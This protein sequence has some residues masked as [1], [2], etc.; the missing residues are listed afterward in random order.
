MAAKAG[1]TAASAA[2]GPDAKMSSWPASAGPLLPDTGASTNITSGRSCR[3]VSSNPVVAESPIVPICAHTAPGANAAARPCGNITM[4]TASAV[5]SMVITTRASLVASRAE[6]A[7]RAP[8]AASGAVA[9]GDLS[10]T[11]V[12]RPAATKLRAIADPMMPVPST[13]TAVPGSG[14]AS[15]RLVI[16]LSSSVAGVTVPPVRVG[17][18]GHIKARARIGEP[19]P[20]GSDDFGVGGAHLT[21]AASRDRCWQ[22]RCLHCRH[23]VLVTG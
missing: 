9:S 7:T 16:D 14:A 5:G 2:A 12:R 19:A 1:P 18:S 6:A 10:H 11:V 3:S 22:R 20:P 8:A 23:P 13:V 17:T 21:A 15:G 4:S